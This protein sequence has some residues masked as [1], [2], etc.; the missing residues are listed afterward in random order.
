MDQNATRE[1]RRLIGCLA[2][3]FLLT[4]LFSSLTPLI[5]DDYNYAFSWA[6]NGRVRSIADIA[7]S[8]ETHRA[9]TNGRVF[10]HGLVQL[11]V[12]LPKAAF[13][14]VNALMLTLLAAVLHGYLRLL[15]AGRSRR[16]C[17]RSVWRSCF[18]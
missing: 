9:Y 2:L 7:A 15:R 16:H 13:N 4:F 12:M 17:S 14:L 18:C 6:T 10:S 5:A 8:M 3:V 11:F 1:R